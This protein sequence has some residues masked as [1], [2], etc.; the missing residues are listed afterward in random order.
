MRVTDNND[1]VAERLTFTLSMPI[2]ECLA[3]PVVCCGFH[4]CSINIDFDQ[5]FARHSFCRSEC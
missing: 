2:T 5:M 1:N 4:A 3:Q